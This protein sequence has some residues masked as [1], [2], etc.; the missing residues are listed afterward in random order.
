MGKVIESGLKS[1]SWDPRSDSEPLRIV[2]S[3]T[4]VHYAT[5]LMIEE[6]QY[7][8]VAMIVKHCIYTVVIQHCWSYFDIS[9][10]F[11]RFFICRILIH[12]FRCISFHCYICKMLMWNQYCTC[13]ILIF[14]CL[15]YL[16]S[17]LTRYCLS[18]DRMLVLCSTGTINL[19]YTTTIL[20]WLLPHLERYHYQC[21]CYWYLNNVIV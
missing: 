13:F 10:I 1:S 5:V 11:F 17:V 6:S 2:L 16:Y 9:V 12:C 20:Y 8:L 18:V 14:I 19:D 7:I 15:C 3:V 4:L 21:G